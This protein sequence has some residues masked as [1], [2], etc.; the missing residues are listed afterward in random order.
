MANHTRPAHA[1]PDLPIESVGARNAVRRF[2]DR[3][4]LGSPATRVWLFTAFLA[5]AALAGYLL[6]VRHLEPFE[7]PVHVP[8]PILAIAYLAAETKVILVHFRRET[9]SFSLSEV[10]AVIG[11]FF[12]TPNEYLLAVLVGSGVALLV[13]ARQSIVKVAFNLAN[14]AL[15]GVVTL[16]VF[17]RI[18]TPGGTP[19][20]VDWLAAFGAMIVPVVIGA[21]TIATA[22]SLSGGAPQFQKLPEM[23]KFGLVVALANTS[24]ALLAV[25]VMW[26]NLSAVLLLLIPLVTIFLAYRAYLSER[27]KHERLE[28]LYQSSRIMQHSPELDSALVALLDHARTMFRAEV[29]EVILYPRDDAREALRTTSIHDG[30]PAVMVPE[31]INFDVGIHSRVVGER[32][33]FLTTSAIRVLA[34]RPIRQAMVSP[35]IGESGLVGAMTVANRLTEGTS[36]DDDD[37]LLLETLANQAAVALENGQLEQSLAELSRLKE[38]LRH[39]AYHDPLTGLA[40][41]AMFAEQVEAQLAARQPGLDAVVLFLDLDDFKLVNDTLGHGAGDRLLRVVAERINGCVR[42]EDLAARLGGDEFAVLLLDTPNLDRSMSV[43]QRIIEALQVPFQIGGSE[44]SV[45]ASI[46]IAATSRS[47]DSADVLLRNADVAMYTAKA[48]GKRRAAVFEPTMHAAL[49]A[50]HSLSAELSR[51]LGR[52]ELAVFFQ[53]IVRLADRKLAGVEALVRWRH[54]TRGLI[55]PG[56]FISLAEE[57]GLILSLGRWVLAEACIRFG[58]WQAQPDVAE[59]FFVSVNLSPLQLQQPEFIDEIE[60]TLAATGLDPRRLVLELT[61]T[62]MFQDTEAT[63]SKLGALRAAGVRIAMDDFGTGYSSLGYL[64]RFPV[65]ILKIARD[66]VVEPDLEQSEWVFAHAIVALGQTL[67]LQIIAEGIE[68]ASQV[69]RLLQMGCEYGQ[70]FHLGAPFDSS[71]PVAMGGQLPATAIR[72]ASRPS[73]D[74]VAEAA[75]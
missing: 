55:L 64:R 29:A 9:H 51:S 17:Y 31:A 39:Q 44:I 63:I 15:I 22:I 70:G 73:T 23:I 13:T 14:F 72:P 49:V 21:L 43:A 28:L 25:S 75:S 33:A 8:W 54:P 61:E 12:V 46:G 41:R 36:F 66:F 4:L 10:P 52:G 45:G 67:G 74:W 58:A 59:D 20:P 18:A 68:E 11:L 26:V 2:F 16:A 57:T 27:E 47:D 5:T 32:R 34:G 1:I 53:P 19:D 6:D 24:L 48:A 71:T 30:A 65:D 56:E 60:S 37:L 62:A 42:A 69:D 40:N 3:G 35:L 50:R 7:S 38:Q